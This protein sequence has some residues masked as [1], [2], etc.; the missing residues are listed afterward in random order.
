MFVDVLFYFHSSIT[1]LSQMGRSI[2]LDS[3]LTTYI[4]QAVY[5]K[6]SG[7]FFIIFSSSRKDLELSKYSVGKKRKVNTK[8]QEQSTL[9]VKTIPS[10]IF[11][12][13]T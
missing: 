3:R 8:T 11:Y 12:Q 10:R 4:P 7:I 5:K 6:L 1:V 9:E 13:F 2:M